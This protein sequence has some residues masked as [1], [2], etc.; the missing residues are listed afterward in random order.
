MDESLTAWWACQNS[1]IKILNTF[2]TIKVSD[3]QMPGYMLYICVWEKIFGFSEF[4]LR[5]AS[6]P[7]AIL[8][9]FILWKMPLSTLFKKIYSILF[10]FSPF[11]WYNLN[12]AR[13]NIIL[14]SL[15]GY[16]LFSIIFYFNREGNKNKKL[17]IYLGT[18]SFLLGLFFSLLFIF[19]IIPITIVIIYFIKVNK[20]KILSLINNIYKYK[21]LIFITLF[22]FTFIMTYYIYTILNDAGGIREFP[23]IFNLGVVMYEFL[24]FSGLGPPRNLVR[25][26]MTVSILP[27]YIF[28]IASLFVLYLFILFYSFWGRLRKELILQSYPFFLSVIV[29]LTTF[30]IVAYIL[31]FQFWGRHLI[32][33]LPYFIYFQSQVVS[34]YFD[35]KKNK[36]FSISFIILIL[37]LI[38]SCLNIRFN[39]NYAKDND[40]LAATMAINLTTATDTILWVGPSASAA[41]YG[42]KVEDFDIPSKWKIYRYAKY[43]GEWSC[44]YFNN[45]IKCNDVPILVI[46][47]KYNNIYK[48]K[49]LSNYNTKR[50][51]ETKD[52]IIYKLK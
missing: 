51:F 10:C 12:E 3:A 23:R 16:I 37:F 2:L 50:H 39:N 13:V 17:V 30:F 8:F 34:K 1:I 4:S 45:F 33:I 26:E 46:Y 41:Y 47:N 32:Y 35:F 14:F 11:I 42:I 22:I 21:G 48:D 5:L 49:F 19:S 24:G 20:L 6:L 38:I 28:K 15:S 36:L 7:F 31:K 44:N 18:L 9:L 25:A 29:T 40:K 52:F 43:V 27:K